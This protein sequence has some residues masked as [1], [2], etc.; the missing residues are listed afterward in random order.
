M[1]FYQLGNNPP[2]LDWDEASLGYNAY[3]ILKTGRDEYGNLLP[4]SIRSFGDYKPPLYVYLAILPVKIFGLTEFSTRLP[5]SILGTLAILIVY[6]LAKELFS[7]S[8]PKLHLIAAYFF[9]ISPW[10]IQFSRIAFEANIGLFFYILAVYL[11]VKSRIRPGLL[12][13]SVTS[14]ALSLYAYHSPR[15]ITPLF[16][17][18]VSVYFRSWVRNHLKVFFFSTVLFALLILPIVIQ[19]KNSSSSRFSSVSSLTPQILTR[20]ITDLADDK[21]RHDTIGIILHNRRIVYIQQVILGYLDHFNLDFLFLT[22][23]PPGRHHA[24]SM[25]MLYLWDGVFIL[26]G[27]YV[28]LRRRKKIIAVL[29]LLFLVAPIASSL[30][31]GT[32]HAVRSIFYL[33]TYQLFCATGFLGFY[34]WS[35][36]RG[37][38]WVK[39]GLPIIMGGLLIVNFYY[40]INM[41]FIHTPVEYSQWWQYGYKQIVEIANA[42]QDKY[43]KIVVTYRYD[44][45]YIFFLFYN[46]V[47]P[48]WYQSEGQKGEIPRMNRQ[49]G[50]Y[51]FRNID[52]GQDKNI[53]KTLFIGSPQEIPAG[54]PGLLKEIHFLDGTVAFRVVGL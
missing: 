12:F 6:L 44:Q 11:M 16:L 48:I 35:T 21:S 50:K 53:T 41:Y 43:D 54:T 22:G 29:F 8:S 2:S 18:L 25:G 26:V 34:K 45:P 49:F 28:L 7:S 20:S 46:S 51:E 17:I 10:H 33:P 38:I 9:A 47:N 32:P 1:R 42:Q 39:R 40:Y 3:S 27:V 13:F 52:W 5:S 36:Q 37:S 23:D 14:F 30:T 19:L 24:S 4:I 31:T 15:L